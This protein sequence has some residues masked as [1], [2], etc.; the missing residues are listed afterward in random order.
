MIAGITVISIMIAVGIAFLALIRAD[1]RQ[2]RE[3]E[4]REGLERDAD[5][6]AA[7]RA[8]GGDLKWSRFLR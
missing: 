1:A 3:Q 5:F 8:I 2:A 7:C 6:M 4:Y